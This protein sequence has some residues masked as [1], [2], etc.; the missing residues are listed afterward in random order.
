[1]KNKYMLKSK[2]DFDNLFLKKTSFYSS[3]YIIYWRKNNLL[4]PRFAISISKKN[5]KLAVRRNKARR[6]IKSI[7]HTY[8]TKKN[9]VDI[10]IIVKKS[11]FNNDFETNKN[12]L[13]N[14]LKKIFK[15]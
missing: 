4:Y 13:I 7:L 1:M 5:E 11:F 3:F 8:S 15:F 10:I 2:N 9:N 6:Q 12:D 14:I